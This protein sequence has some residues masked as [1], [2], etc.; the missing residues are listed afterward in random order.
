MESWVA[1]YWFTVYWVTSV[2]HPDCWVANMIHDP[3]ACRTT[4]GR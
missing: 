4:Y 3:M 1:Q 2:T